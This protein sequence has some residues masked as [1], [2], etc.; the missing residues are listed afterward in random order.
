[1]AGVG[2]VPPGGEAA[3]RA[4]LRARAAR[5]GGAGVGRG[6]AGHRRCAGGGDGDRGVRWQPGCTGMRPCWQAA[7]VMGLST[8]VKKTEVSQLSQRSKSDGSGGGV[9]QCKKPHRLR[10]W[11]RC[12]YQRFGQR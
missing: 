2:V 6:G 3:D 5:A 12:V 1:M 10:W 7:I 4:Q 8:I 9:S 11:L